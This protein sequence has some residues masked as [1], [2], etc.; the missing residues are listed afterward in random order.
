MSA[1][2]A[3]PTY[4]RTEAAYLVSLAFQSRRPKTR[5]RIIE[6]AGV[7][8]K[9]VDV[10]DTK[11]TLRSGNLV[12][13]V[14]I[15]HEQELDVSEIAELAAFT[16][17][18]RIMRSQEDNIEEL[19]LAIL[20][21][22]KDSKEIVMGS[23]AAFQLTDEA[24]LQSVNT[25]HLIPRDIE[26]VL[27]V[28]A[29]L[30]VAATS[31]MKT[32]PEY[33]AAIAKNFYAASA[34]MCSN[35]WVQ[36]KAA[37][38]ISYH[39]VSKR[40]RL[41]YNLI[42]SPRNRKAH[43]KF[44]PD[45]IQVK[46]V[47]QALT[48]RIRRNEDHLSDVEYMYSGPIRI[49]KLRD[50]AYIMSTDNIR[51]IYQMIHRRC[52]AVNNAT[53]QSITMPHNSHVSP[54]D[55]R[56]LTAC[57]IQGAAN[58]SKQG[59]PIADA[60]KSMHQLW[61]AHFAK[62]YESIQDEGNIANWKDRYEEICQKGYD[63][64]ST[65]RA[66]NVIACRMPQN[67]AL[68]A[69]RLHHVL[70]S[71]D[72]PPELVASLTK[73]IPETA[74]KPHPAR[75]DAF[76]RFTRSY[77]LCVYLLK[78]KK[79][80]N[81]AG[82]VTRS[83]APCYKKCMRGKFALPQESDWGELWISEH[84]PYIKHSDQFALRAKDATRIPDDRVAAM[85]Q[86]HVY[87]SWEHNELLHAIK[88]GTNLGAPRYLSIQ[89]ARDEFWNRKEMAH[90]LVV[91]A[92]KAEVTKTDNKPRCTFSA[93]GEFRQAQAEF[94]RNCQTINDLIGC[95]SLRA[96]PVSH[97]KGIARVCKNTA[98]NY[99]NT[100][101]DVESWSPSQDRESWTDY[102]SIYIDAF[103]GLNADSY[104]KSWGC[105]DCVTAKNSRVFFDHVPNGGIQ[106][107]PG[108][109][110]TSHH[111]MVLIYFLH[112]MREANRI[113]RDVPTLAKAYIDDCLAQMATWNGELKDL[114][115]ELADHY[116]KLGYQIDKVKSV[117]SKCKAIYLNQAMIRGAIVAQGTKVMC[118]VDRP[119]EVVLKT[120]M[121]D[122]SA[123]YAGC[124]AAIQAGNEPLSSYFLSS[125]IAC[126]YLYRANSSIYRMNAQAST[127][128]HIAPRGD[129]GLGIPTL[130]DI[131]CKEHPD[132]R[133]Q[134]NHSIHMYFK[135]M[136]LRNAQAHDHALML[137][138]AMKTRPMSIVSKA[139]I[140]FNPR[141]VQREGIPALEAVKRHA[142]IGAAKLWS[143]AD[144]YRGILNMAKNDAAYSVYA[145][146]LTGCKDGVDAAFLEAY[147]A[148]LPE[149]MLDS[150]VGKVASYKVASELLGPR[151]VMSI[152]GTI[153]A[154]FDL[155]VSSWKVASYPEGLDRITV[156]DT[157]ESVSGVSRTRQEREEFYALNMVRILNHTIASPF[158]VI[159]VGS[160]EEGPISTA[161]VSS[162]TGSLRH[163]APDCPPSTASLVSKHGIGVPLRSQGW[164]VE[165]A[166]IHKNLD[167]VSHKFVEGCA[168]IE[169]AKSTGED[170]RA[171]E[172]T[173]L[174]RWFGPTDF[175]TSM[176]VA[177]SMQGSVKRATAAAGSRSHPIFTNVN[178]QKSTL[179]N[180]TALQALITE[181]EY[182]ID[183]L[184]MVSVCYA[185]GSFNMGIMINALAKAKID[186]IDFHWSI[187]IH[188]DCMFERVPFVAKSQASLNALMSIF[189]LELD[190][191]A[192]IFN[193]GG[194]ETQLKMITEP[195]ALRALL[196]GQTRIM[197][198][199]DPGTYSD[200]TETQDLA[201]MYGVPH[202]APV[203]VEF[204]VG[205]PRGVAK[206]IV[207]T[208]SF[209]GATKVRL[210]EISA[211]S[212]KTCAFSALLLSA[213]KIGKSQ[214]A[215]Y[216]V[217]DEGVIQAKSVAELA[218]E[219]A[220]QTVNVVS[221]NM[222]TS[223]PILE[224]ARGLRACGCTGFDW[225]DP[226]HLDVEHMARDF[227]KW[228]SLNVDKWMRAVRQTI[229]EHAA[230]G[231]SD[232]SVLTRAARFSKDPAK[233]NASERKIQIK[234]KFK[235][236]A[237]AY[238]SRMKLI[239]S[240]SAKKA[241]D[242]SGGKNAQAARIAFLSGACSMMQ[243][244]VFTDGPELDHLS[245][246][247]NLVNHIVS[248]AE[249]KGVIGFGMDG[250]SLLDEGVIDLTAVRVAQGVKDTWWW[251]PGDYAKGVLTAVEWASEDCRTEAEEVYF[252]PRNVRVRTRVR[253]HLVGVER[254]RVP[255]LDISRMP[256]YVMSQTA[257]TMPSHVPDPVDS[258]ESF[259]QV[260]E[261][262]EE[263]A[264]AMFNAVM[265]RAPKAPPRDE[266]AF[267]ESLAL[268]QVAVMV[269]ELGADIPDGMADM[270]RQAVVIAPRKL[271]EM[272]PSDEALLRG[273]LVACLKVT[274]G[275][276]E[277]PE[278]V[279]N[280][281][282][283]TYV[284]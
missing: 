254:P 9:F 51:R 174:R 30:L 217:G 149:S 239:K 230:M 264:L 16:A 40:V 103:V 181:E 145:S 6:L 70:A 86:H 158:E 117:I 138:A 13:D 143:E 236:R 76:I 58:N 231:A 45:G 115:D 184:S 182:D 260:E 41:H 169:W 192:F 60:A 152:Q 81:V 68:D 150:I 219:C 193:G 270:S 69:L 116:I 136:P 180:V 95:G 88:R 175:G 39:T 63:L 21:F 209:E 186:M 72:T 96:D 223:M 226:D 104:K 188:T 266:V 90:N 20:D 257:G 225:Y 2:D 269:G 279:A 129:G 164:I 216:F 17:E 141:S 253:A 26:S 114:E 187:G 205:K 132:P 23:A 97:A 277:A 110:D 73:A 207:V 77:I 271:T 100:S 160:V 5:D 276:L 36:R 252:V 210:L 155:I 154:K 49:V 78:H 170:M 15:M 283:L 48:G 107:F 79:W 119:M 57:L 202:I 190:D 284:M 112:R 153:N 238:S 162:D 227:G 111:V 265:S 214:V 261:S 220:K 82:D 105:F 118:K 56:Q 92:A 113:P 208:D 128:A 196:L 240:N 4:T 256:V 173:Y 246:A 53:L 235:A 203:G 135:G 140:F 273:S 272:D 228:C 166:D 80:P 133:A 27:P 99:T 85:S 29:E 151:E 171:W 185:F 281:E 280:E 263:D 237:A 98:I 241:S 199:D 278:F 102:V 122:A 75:H 34:R 131:T 55:V 12:D 224:A 66:M 156:L 11:D 22:V 233:A 176:F 195:G 65:A 259:E 47:T 50:K 179:V 134:A 62:A 89:Q 247:N 258:E 71:S 126:S 64:C 183:P 274:K 251:R 255:D 244:M 10:L 212:A 218:E 43:A 124:K 282:D 165:H 221:Q 168:V 8:A 38:D 161:S 14:D 84:F 31:P 106:G 262:E 25:A 245:S 144:P 243:S 125:V 19:C 234:K 7:D 148:H 46:Q 222:A 229:P 201:P 1:V 108:T 204:V 163:W 42:I 137:F 250:A 130:A 232:Y 24:I 157:I 32:N 87:A 121:D 268:W 189:E 139:R 52:M 194:C 123:C 74:R 167:A 18:S 37:E 172:L 147:S 54:N 101:H 35:E 178:L 198:G 197:D 142:V 109:L 159:T 211:W 59:R 67:I 275:R 44:F 28:A 94:D 200:I 120:P 215:R 249:E 248:K 83:D 242:I 61:C 206:G 91:V 146:L 93:T 177:A 191:D 267:V 213:E 3:K 33:V 127:L